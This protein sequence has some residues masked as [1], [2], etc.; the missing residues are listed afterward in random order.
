MDRFFRHALSVPRFLPNFSVIAGAIAEDSPA[1]AR[2][3]SS[4]ICPNGKIR[5]E[6]KLVSREH[7]KESSKILLCYSICWRFSPT[8]FFNLT[9]EKH[10]FSRIGVKRE[11]LQTG[12]KSF[13]YSMRICH[14]N[15]GLSQ[16]S[17]SRD[18][19]E[20]ICCHFPLS[21]P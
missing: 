15:A 1:A 7:H 20:S 5:R 9:T 2:H 16:A 19:S 17:T 4:Q 8:H 11:L 14:V 13:A 10:L 6:K 18:T 3:R 21:F 12:R